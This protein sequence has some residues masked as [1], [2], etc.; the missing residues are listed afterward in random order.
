M[1]PTSPPPHGVTARF[2]YAERRRHEMIDAI[3][4]YHASGH[5]PSAWLQE[6]AELLGEIEAREAGRRE[7]GESLRP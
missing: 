2:V 7:R 1:T 6:A 3:A 5:R 4:R